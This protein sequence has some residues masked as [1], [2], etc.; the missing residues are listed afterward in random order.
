MPKDAL[1]GEPLEPGIYT[2]KIASVSPEKIGTK[3]LKE[4]QEMRGVET[5]LVEKPGEAP[6]VEVRVNTIVLP[7]KKK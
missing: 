3:M 6:K 1:E 5:E 4:L 2:R 7:Q